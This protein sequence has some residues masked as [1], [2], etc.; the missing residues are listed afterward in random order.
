MQRALTLLQSGD[1]IDR[2]GLLGT[3]QQVPFP[4]AKRLGL[5]SEEEVTF[6][7][8]FPETDGVLVIK[9]IVPNGPLS[10]WA[11][12]GDVLLS[13]N[14]QRIIGFVELD[15]LLDDNVGSSVSIEVQRAGTTIQKD[16]VV[17]D[18]HQVSPDDLIL[19]CNGSFNDVSYQLARHYN[20]PI[21]GVTIAFAGYC[22]SNAGIERGN[23]IRSINDIP[24]D[25][26]DQLWSALQKLEDDQPIEVAYFSFRNPRQLNRRIVHWDRT[27]FP[28][29]RWTRNDDLGRWTIEEGASAP[30]S[31]GVTLYPQPNY[32]NQQVSLPKKDKW[33]LKI[34]N[35]L[36]T[37]KYSIPLSVE[38]VYGNAFFGAGVIVDAERGLVSVDR[39]TVPISLG[40][41]EIIFAGEVRVPGKVVYLHPE[42]NISLLQFDV[43]KLPAGSFSDDMSLMESDT[44]FA[45]SEGEAVSVYGLD[46]D[47]IFQGMKTEVERGLFLQMP[48][49]RRPFFREANL[50]VGVLKDSKELVGG[51]VVNKKD[52]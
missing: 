14:G 10:E 4:D 8:Q 30:E 52:S 40:D 33:G 51:V 16:V 48:G 44:G 24:I 26:T 45:W 42:H 47:Y 12:V 9:Q 23:V 28:L 22:F 20:I 15:A 41:L 35:A 5:S 43:S 13:I 31:S 6:R 27:W 17:A 39:D 11:R 1:E 36:V 49:A 18:L 21:K 3:F 38:G 19:G 34:Q 25:N 2:G 32:E 37:V 29:E 46:Y 50:D 7:R